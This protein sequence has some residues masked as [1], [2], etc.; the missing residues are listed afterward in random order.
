MI[1]DFVGTLTGGTDVSAAYAAGP[2]VVVSGL[3]CSIATSFLR[4]LQ[5]KQ[6][7]GITHGMRDKGIVNLNFSLDELSPPTP[8][9]RAF[10]ACFFEQNLGS[11]P[12]FPLNPEEITLQLPLS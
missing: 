7:R 1:R 8:H 5:D 6:I 12:T 10:R 4:Y 3:L 2:R 11:C 9:F